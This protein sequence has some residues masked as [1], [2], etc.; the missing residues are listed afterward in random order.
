MRVT[1][2]IALAYLLYSSVAALLV[3]LP[4]SRRLRVAGECAAT[5]LMVV[6]LANA[7]E[8]EGPSHG[9]IGLVRDW[10]PPLFVLASYW[11]P[12]GLITGIDPAAERAL[13]NFD[14][15]W[16]ARP[17]AA[18]A[19]TPAWVSELLEL[20]YLACYPMLPAA[21][22]AVYLWGDPDHADRF[23]AGVI[24]AAALSYGFLPWIR[25]RPPRL[26][27]SEPPRPPSRVR[28]LNEWILSR[29]SV[30]LNTFPSGHV[31]TSVA[32]ALAAS[33]EV[34]VSGLVFLPLAVAISV[35]C[36]VRRYHY[37]A[38][39]LTGACVG[40]AGFAVSRLI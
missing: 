2:W 6:L 38:D 36:V 7:A 8:S 19:R 5:A 10:S 25:T 13:R 1:E 22:A 34:P 16:A 15:R 26:V 18:M 14:A 20:A 35:A 4:L 37:L 39:A 9:W 11:I 12:A 32:A 30:E 3:R 17:M 33:S 21:F 40:A 29:A 24:V 27:E 31:A 23:W 28:T